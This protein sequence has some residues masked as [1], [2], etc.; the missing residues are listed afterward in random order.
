[1]QAHY[2]S[3]DQQAKLIE[4]RSMDYDSA[5]RD[6]LNQGFCLHAAFGSHNGVIHIIIYNIIIIIE[7][8]DFYRLDVQ[9]LK[10]RIV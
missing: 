8:V 2:K 1:M 9:V 6:P 5:E 7:N 4:F 10:W 3:S